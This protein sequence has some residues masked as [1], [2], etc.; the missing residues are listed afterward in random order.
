M[1]NSK[2]PK[3]LLFDIG[4]VCVRTLFI[5]FV[6]LL[7]VFALVY[8]IDHESHIRRMHCIRI[9]DSVKYWLPCQVV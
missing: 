7:L 3:V 4:G 5:V 2:Q 9:V 1:A 8:C 6:L